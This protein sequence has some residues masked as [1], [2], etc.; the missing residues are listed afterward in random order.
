M[1]GSGH[2]AQFVQS[3]ANFSTAGELSRWVRPADEGHE[4]TK[5]FCANCGSPIYGTTT[6]NDGIVVV[7]IGALDEP[8]AIH[9]EKIIFKDE[10]QPWDTISV[11]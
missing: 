9:P 11:C 4:L 3:S 2:A 7:L 5:Y 6:R 10:R 1:T 8:S